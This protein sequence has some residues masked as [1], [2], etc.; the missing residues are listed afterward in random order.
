M[1]LVYRKH[2]AWVTALGMVPVYVLLEPG[3]LCLE[4]RLFFLQL[5]NLKVFGDSLLGHL[6]DL[7]V[8]GS[9]QSC[10][11]FTKSTQEEVWECSELLLFSL[12]LL[13][14]P[15]GVYTQLASSL[16]GHIRRQTIAQFK[17]MVLLRKK[18]PAAS[19]ANVN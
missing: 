18:Y 14:R 15:R 1:A 9:F 11:I 10:Y 12:M 3:H 8:P 17:T 5:M 2:S 4:L 7:G 13:Y 19:Q 6:R 16:K